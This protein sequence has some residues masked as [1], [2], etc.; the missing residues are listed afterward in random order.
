MFLLKLT[1]ICM[2]KLSF[3]NIHVTFTA[4]LY[5]A[6]CLGSAELPVPD[7]LKVT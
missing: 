6:F 2:Y 4:W 7:Y 3:K 1:L 5:N